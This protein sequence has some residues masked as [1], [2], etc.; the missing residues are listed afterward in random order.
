[1]SKRFK[2]ATGAAVAAAVA[3][4]VAVPAASLAHGGHDQHGQ[5]DQRRE[6]VR[7]VL[8]ISVDGL[9]QSDLDWYVAH[10]PAR[11]FPSSPEA[12]PNTP[13]HTR[14]IRRTQTQAGPR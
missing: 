8:L 6:S 10:H 13:T 11:S 4:A 5:H 3:G 14:P 9:H 1:M 2:L 7:H 12:A